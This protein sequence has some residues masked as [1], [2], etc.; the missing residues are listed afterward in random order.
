M[1]THLAEVLEFVL[2]NHGSD[3]EAL[4]VAERYAV[5]GKERHAGIGREIEIRRIG[6]V[7]VGV[8]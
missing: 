3:G 4:Q 8:Q 1:E 6:E 5:L 7:T 2:A